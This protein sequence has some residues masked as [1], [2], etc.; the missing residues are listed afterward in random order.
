MIDIGHWE[1]SQEFNPDDWFGFIYRIVEINSGKEY[2]GKKQFHQHLRVVVKNKKNRK[3]VIKPSNWKTYTSSSTHVNNAIALN[4]KENYKFIIES[5][6]VSKASLHYEE[7]RVQILED[8]LR[9]KMEDGTRKY[10]NG[11]IGGVK[12]LPPEEMSEETR[13]KMRVSMIERYKIDPMWRSTLSAEEMELLNDKYYRGKNH[14]LYRLMDEDTRTKFMNENLIG[15]NNPM[16]GKVGELHPNYGKSYD[17]FHTL[18]PARQGLS[19]E[20][21]H[22]EATAKALRELLSKVQKDLAQK[23]DY[24]NPFKDKTHSDEQKLKWAEDRRGTNAGEDNPMYGKKVTDFMSDE[25]I[26]AWKNNISKSTKGKPK[27]AEHKARLKEASRNRKDLV[28][29]T[30][31][32][33]GKIGKG[34][35]MYRYH[36]DNCKLKNSDLLKQIS[37]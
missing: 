27:S 33:C 16:Y 6:H 1:Y 10:F 30:C 17:E 19:Y 15:K 9:E 18:P 12:F 36:F 14:Y 11:Q 28:E 5:L 13:M 8:V 35:T 25:E 37:K 7:V 20:E 31:V 29:L 2:L 3:K 34:P 23:P 24:I 21:Y 26:Q 22:G 32:H 4:G